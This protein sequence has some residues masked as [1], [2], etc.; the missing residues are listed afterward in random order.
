MNCRWLTMSYHTGKDI[1][2]ISDVFTPRQ[3]VRALREV[4]EKE[5]YLKEVDR[6]AFLNNT[7]DPFWTK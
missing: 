1:R 7:S 2:V 5:I 4:L 6:D 3:F